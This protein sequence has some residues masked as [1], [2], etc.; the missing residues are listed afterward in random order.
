MNGYQEYP[1]VLYGPLGIEDTKIVNTEEEK[2]AAL[3][4]GYALLPPAPE[5]A[6]TPPATYIPEEPK[7]KKRQKENR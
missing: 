6:V 2:R 4:D 7:P 1:R 5:S 3:K